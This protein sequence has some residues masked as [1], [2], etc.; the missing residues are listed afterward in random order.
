MSGINIALFGAGLCEYDER[1]QSAD[2]IRNGSALGG[3]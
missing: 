2:G 3:K 1:A